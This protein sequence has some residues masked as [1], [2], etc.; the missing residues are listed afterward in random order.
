PQRLTDAHDRLDRW[1]TAGPGS[2]ALEPVRAALD[3]DLD[4]PTALALIDEAADAGRG[5]SEA[6][7]L[8]GVLVS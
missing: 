8:L 6:A 5:V 3:D 7:G 1:R 4:V 2:A